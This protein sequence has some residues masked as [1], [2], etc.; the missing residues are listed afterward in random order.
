MKFNTKYKFDKVSGFHFSKPSLTDQS[1][2][3]DSDINNI[4]K[5][6]GV[7]QTQT[8]EPIYGAEFN[9]NMFNDALNVV[10][11]A[12]S[13]FEKLPAYVRREFDNDIQKF[14]SFVDSVP[15]DELKA[16]KAVQL[17]IYKPEILETFKTVNT[18]EQNLVQPTDTAVTQTASGYSAV[19]E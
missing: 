7:V 1:Q 9:P 16:K 11:N 10:T 17:G 13:E 3:Y 5:A 15:G 6:S 12:K 8:N 18:V 14:V 19:S 4:V 2:A